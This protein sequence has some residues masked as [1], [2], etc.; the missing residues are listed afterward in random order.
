MMIIQSSTKGLM[1]ID[2]KRNKK[3]KRFIPTA[4]FRK[5]WNPTADIAALGARAKGMPKI[6]P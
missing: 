1:K 5:I 2:P 4:V 3:T 6:R